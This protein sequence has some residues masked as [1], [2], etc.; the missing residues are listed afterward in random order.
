MARPKKI[1]PLETANEPSEE[2]VK[3]ELAEPL[4]A[5]KALGTFKDGNLSAQFAKFG[6]KVEWKSGEVRHIPVWLYRLCLASGGRFE[7]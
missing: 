3:V 5:V 2:P 4:L 7:L 6:Y 1:Q